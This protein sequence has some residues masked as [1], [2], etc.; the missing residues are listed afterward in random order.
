MPIN[1]L[2]HEYDKAKRTLADMVQKLKFLK[3]GLHECKAEIFKAKCERGKRNAEESGFYPLESF[4]IRL[5]ALGAEPLQAVVRQTAAKL[6]VSEV[7]QQIMQEPKI[8]SR[9][10]KLKL[11]TPPDFVHHQ[12]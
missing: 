3:S 6:P 10:E 1:L 11:Y 5:A 9:L 2:V 8:R 7:N 12:I 4:I